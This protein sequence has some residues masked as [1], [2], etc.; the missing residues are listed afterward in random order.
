[1]YVPLK[2]FRTILLS[3]DILLA[4]QDLSEKGFAHARLFY[5]PEQAISPLY[6]YIASG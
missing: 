1:M 2:N 5:L 6:L 3:P 4:Q